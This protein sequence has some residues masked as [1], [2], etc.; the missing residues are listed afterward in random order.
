LSSRKKAGRQ[1]DSPTKTRSLFL[2][3]FLLLTA[4]Y[5]FLLPPTPQNHLLPLLSFVTA[6]PKPERQG[7]ESD[8]PSQS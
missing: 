2:L 3:P 1:F 4:S 6:S 8:C 5:L 7:A